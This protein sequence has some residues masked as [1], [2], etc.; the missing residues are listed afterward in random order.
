LCVWD[1][2]LRMVIFVFERTNPSNELNI[3]RT[4]C[5]FFFFLPQLDNLFSLVTL[6]KEKL[7]WNDYWRWNFLLIEGD[8]GS[9]RIMEQPSQSTT[10]LFVWAYSSSSITSNSTLSLPNVFELFLARERR[11][12]SCFAD[13]AH[14]T[15]EYLFI[16]SQNFKILI[17][18]KNT[19]QSK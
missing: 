9:D 3:S 4:F 11:W 6:C 1:E 8:G 15:Y 12:R 18:N 19:K 13:L 2:S 10:C 14:Y 7:L 5:R 17:V 16:T